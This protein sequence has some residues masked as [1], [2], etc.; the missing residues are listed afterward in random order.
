MLK[1]PNTRVTAHGGA[2]IGKVFQQVN[3]I[4]QGLL[5]KAFANRS[6]VPG[7]FLHDQRMTSTRSAS[8]GSV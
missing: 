6:V 8:A 1:P 2:Q 7:W 4:E 5:S 3:M